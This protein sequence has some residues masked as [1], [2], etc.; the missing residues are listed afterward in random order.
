MIKNTH[1]GF[2]GQKSNINNINLKGEF[3]K[4]TFVRNEEPVHKKRKTSIIN[5]INFNI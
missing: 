3:N 2:F 4:T 1:A 5:T